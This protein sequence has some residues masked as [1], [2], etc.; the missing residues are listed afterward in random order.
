MTIELAVGAPTTMLSELCPLGGIELCF[1]HLL[2]GNALRSVEPK[3]GMK[4]RSIR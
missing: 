1:A 3:A 2:S 4:F